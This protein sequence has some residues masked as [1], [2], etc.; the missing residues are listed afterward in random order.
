MKIPFYQVNAFTGEG[1]KGNPAGVCLL[2]SWLSDEIMQYIAYENQFSET[3]FVVKE[4]GM[5][6]IRWFT[7]AI[8]V[9]LC[10]HATLAAASVIMQFIEK[11]LKQV[12]FDSRSGALT[13]SKYGSEYALNFP[14]DEISE[15]TSMG[16]YFSAFHVNPQLVFKGKTDYMFVFSSESQIRDMNPDL[17]IV[18]QLDARGIIVTAP[19]DTVDFVSRFFGPQ[20]G[21]PEDPVTGSAH[22]TLTP[23]WSGRLKKNILHAWQLSKRGGVLKC[24]MLKKRVE[25]TGAV[26]N[27]IVGF[28]II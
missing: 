8:E 22:T 25:I 24:T 10:G 17:E 28:I 4:D 20:S 2:D 15:A 18:N 26:Q 27:Y 12:Q 3:A 11:D 16:K 19:G 14:A 21:I 9:D 1:F 23:Y 5:Y 6:K 13:V 7:P